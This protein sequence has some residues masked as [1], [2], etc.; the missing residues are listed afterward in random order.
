MTQPLSHTAN[1]TVFNR[2]SEDLKNKYGRKVYLEFKVRYHRS[3][4]AK[5]SI[6]T[7]HLYITITIKETLRGK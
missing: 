1:S 4:E 7:T 2:P 6:L 3:P 5:E